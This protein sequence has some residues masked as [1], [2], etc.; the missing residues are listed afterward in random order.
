MLGVVEEH[1]R[2]PASESEG[3]R[4]RDRSTS[5]LLQ[6]ERL[7][8]SR[9]ESGGITERRQWDPYDAV[10]KGVRGLGSRLDRQTGLPRSAGSC[11]REQTDVLAYEE[12]RAVFKFRRTSEERRRLNREACPVE[13]VKR[14]M[15]AVSELKQTL[16]CGEIL[17]AMLTQVVQA[18]AV[19][20]LRRR[21]GHEHLT[22]VA[23]GRDPRR[24]MNV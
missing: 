22:P 10:G 20:N 15:L 17:Q 4:L 3:E 19:E 6:P 14:R 13:R 23:R 16:R 12:F 5:V 18:P 21:R 11:K 2:P 8:D 24:S 1:E 9:F 7:G